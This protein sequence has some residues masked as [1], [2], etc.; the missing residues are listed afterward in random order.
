MAGEQSGQ[1]VPAPSWREVWQLPVLLLGVGLFVAGLYLA[2]PRSEPFD[3]E[4]EAS[5]A[6]KQLETGNFA[7]A[8]QTLQNIQKHLGANSRPEQGRLAMMMGDSLFLQQRLAGTNVPENNTNVANFYRQA[9]ELGQR[10]DGEHLQRL[11]ETQLALGQDDLALQTLDELKNQPA[12]RG[13][14]F[15]QIIEHRLHKPGT[16]TAAGDVLLD[17]YLKELNQLPAGKERRADEVW[18]ISM[19]MQRVMDSSG[20]DA[21]IDALLP[22]ITRLSR[23]VGSDGKPVGD[24]DLAPLDILLAQAYQKAGDWLKARRS[25]EIA[26]GKLDSSSPAQ[27][28]LNAAALVG[29]GQV[30]LAQAGD[31]TDQKAVQAALDLFANAQSNYPSTPS[32]LAAIIGKA[33]SEAL[34]GQHDRA[35]DDFGLAV[36]K[37]KE[38][39]RAADVHVPTIVAAVF[40]RA[41]VDAV[42]NEPALA[43]RYLELLP[44][45]YAGEQPPDLLLK[46]AQ[47]HELLGRQLQNQA[48]AVVNNDS[49]P[50]P[51][52]AASQPDAVPPGGGASAAGSAASE[53]SSRPK[54]LSATA[55]QNLRVEAADHFDRGGRP[56]STSCPDRHH[57]RG[58]GVRVESLAVRQLL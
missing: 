40:D 47:A 31:G 52:P 17:Q 50:A 30:T 24:Q 2:R 42:R 36:K 48:A 11:I 10:L 57:P 15:H 4:K 13:A 6:R 28:T 55:R 23:Q 19:K 37:I 46:T 16:G 32:F 22:E 5:Q 21:A 8:D 51:G 7:Q 26:R 44:P 14:V 34:L 45:L 3:F 29:L 43:L 1:A 39:G 41:R 38:Q 25:F 20:Q 54:P 33:Q 53:E 27:A 12:S 56:L 35:V 49:A 18:A 58:R 9:R